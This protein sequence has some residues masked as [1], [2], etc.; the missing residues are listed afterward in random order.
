MNSIVWVNG[1]RKQVLASNEVGDIEEMEHLSML[2]NEKGLDCEIQL[3]V[4]TTQRVTC[5]AMK[6]TNL[7]ECYGYEWAFLH[8]QMLSSFLRVLLHLLSFVS[9]AKI[10]CRPYV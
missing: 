3:S 6:M 4:S 5:G 8:A 10:H 2:S 9:L 7:S 1:I